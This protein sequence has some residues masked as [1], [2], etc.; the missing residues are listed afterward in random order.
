MDDYKLATANA[1][2][3]ADFSMENSSNDMTQAIASMTLEA[4]D[5]VSHKQQQVVKVGERNEKPY[6]TSKEV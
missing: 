6:A 3:H 2:I 5:G 4:G 1:S